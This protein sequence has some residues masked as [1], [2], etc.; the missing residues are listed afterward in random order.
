[1]PIENR[2]DLV[3]VTGRVLLDDMGQPKQIIDVNDIR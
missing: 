2:R 3:Q 1:L